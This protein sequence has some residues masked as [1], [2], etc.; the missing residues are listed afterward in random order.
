MWLD[1]NGLAHLTVDTLTARQRMV[2]YEMLISKIRSVNGQLWVSAANGTIA[3][4]VERE[5][6]FEITL[7]DDNMFMVGDYMRCQ[8]FSGADFRSYWV[9]ISG[10]DGG[11][12]YVAKSEFGEVLPQEGDDVILCGSKN[13][14]RQN[15]IHISATEDGQP[16][17]SLYNGIATKD[18]K[19]CLRTQLGNLDNIEDD[20][21]N[22]QGDGL[23]SDNAYLK[24]EFI[25]KNSGKSVDTLFA[26]TE[27][28]IKASVEQ[29]QGEAIKGKTLLYNASF[30]DGLKGWLT[31]NE[32]NTYFSGNSLL[33]TSGSMLAQSVTVSNEPIYDNVFF[34][35]I[36]NG[37]IKQ[38]NLY[39]IN[40]P[41]FEADKQYP[42][43]FSTN[44]RC[45]ESGILNVYLTNIEASNANTFIGYSDDEY[46]DSDYIFVNL[47]NNNTSY[48]LQLSEF[49]SISA[50]DKIAVKIGKEPKLFN[51]TQGYE[52][53]LTDWREEQ[54]SDDYVIL[55]EPCNLIYTGGVNKSATFITLDIDG[56]TW[57]GQGDF[58]LS[59]S[60]DADFYGFTIFTE[61]TEVRHQTL[62]EQTDKLIKISA[63]NFDS[64]GNVLESS[65]ITTTAKMN[66]AISEKFNEDGSLKNTAGIVTSTDLENMDLVDN[67]QLQGQLSKYV[68]TESFAGLF[69]AAVEDDGNVVKTSTLAAYVKEDD[70]GNLVSQIDIEADQINLTGYNINVDAANFKVREDGSIEAK[71]ALFNGFVQK[72]TYYITDENKLGFFT[73]DELNQNNW[74][75][76]IGTL[77]PIIVL[78]FTEANKKY[79]RFKLPGYDIRTS[80][81]ATLTLEALAY[82]RSFIGSDIF[83]YNYTENECRFD[84]VDST[85]E[86][87][88]GVYP[89]KKGEFIQFRCNFDYW[90]T[91]KWQGEFIYWEVV[92]TGK[93]IPIAN[94]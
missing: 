45:N 90:S 60:G 55:S 14:G 37:W 88:V 79:I 18:L 59:F 69:A 21:L 61:K 91:S 3:K 36:K 47:A 94:N 66:A 42:L 75:A 35:N 12:L 68:E 13:V 80:T 50:G 62:F 57:N 39:F 58:Y 84:F 89:I 9:E 43:F 19:G 46:F 31:S 15:A 25:L 44:I 56:L 22:P 48:A 83:V 17:I 76:E 16:R 34:V 71:N 1:E 92:H 10:V 87:V 38:S 51:L 85:G 82:I 5:N 54:I 32:D 23:Y 24:G 7:E 53:P 78:K 86:N 26:I 65:S 73:V 29:T 40:K 74:S 4:V 27:E 11:R 8:V 20:V 52:I 81:A 30:I 41:K 63:Q 93:A 6:D 28:G 64:N 70:L 2:I 72:G 67:E 77:S 49:G 33:F